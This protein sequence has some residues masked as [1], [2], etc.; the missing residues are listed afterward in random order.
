MGGGGYSQLLFSLASVQVEP[1]VF[2][3]FESLVLSCSLVTKE[4]LSP[5]QRLPFGILFSLF[6]GS[7]QKTQRSLRRGEEEKQKFLGAWSNNEIIWGL[8]LFRL[9]FNPWRHIMGQS[10][11]SLLKAD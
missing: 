11:S 3:D 10:E 7:L 2:F 1:K 4:R 5:P 9:N 6:P 8:T